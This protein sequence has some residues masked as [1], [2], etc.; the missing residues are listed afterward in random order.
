MAKLVLFFN[1]GF[2]GLSSC[3]QS[4]TERVFPLIYLSEPTYCFTNMPCS[5]DLPADYPDT[6][7]TEEG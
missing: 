5:T 6:L 2:S 7:A 4:S 1:H 3:C